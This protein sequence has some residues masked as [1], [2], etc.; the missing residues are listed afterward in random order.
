MSLLPLKIVFYGCLTREGDSGCRGGGC[1]EMM[2]A[3][4]GGWSWGWR[5]TKGKETK[6]EARKR[7]RAK[8]DG[9]GLRKGR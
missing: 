8:D 3:G 1:G 5:S 6:G 9:E 4:C 2:R 7:R